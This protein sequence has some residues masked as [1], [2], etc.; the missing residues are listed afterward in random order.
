MIERTVTPTEDRT[1]ADVLD[2]IE[3]V[4]DGRGWVDVF[5]S[6]PVKIGCAVVQRG[7]YVQVAKPAETRIRVFVRRLIDP[8]VRTWGD[9]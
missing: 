6:V 5:V 7:V 3:Y 4:H 8:A 9:A 1:M 2:Q